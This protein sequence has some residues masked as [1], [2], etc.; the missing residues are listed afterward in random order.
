ML[1]DLILTVHRLDQPF[2]SFEGYSPRT[3]PISKHPLL[4]DVS[5]SLRKDRNPF[6][7]PILGA[8][9]IE[10]TVGSN[11]SFVPRRIEASPGESISVTL[12]NPDVVPHNWALLK[13]GSLARAGAHVNKL[14]TDPDAAA[15][16]YIPASDDVL[17]YTDIVDPHSRF[18]I[19]F[20]LPQTV[21]R[22]PFFCTFPGHW[23]VMNGELIVE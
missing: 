7:K 8:R 5:R 21:G 18:T 16:Q 11:L 9:A 23:M 2:T 15:R 13:P 12:I 10:I 3:T 1:H 20:K 14:V 4:V 19:H 6:E 22:Y 17:A